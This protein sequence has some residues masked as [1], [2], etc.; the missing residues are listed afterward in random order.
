[1]VRHYKAHLPEVAK[2]M[3]ETRKTSPI[4]TRNPAVFHRRENG[5]YW[6][7]CSVCEVGKRSATVSVAKTFEAT[8]MKTC[9]DKF[10]SVRWMFDPTVEKPSR[11]RTSPPAPYKFKTADVQPTQPEQPKQGLTNEELQ[12]RF[13]GLFDAEWLEVHD[14]STIADVPQEEMLDS[15]QKKYKE[16]QKALAKA[17]RLVDAERMEAEIQR[18]VELALNAKVAVY[19][20]EIAELTAENNTLRCANTTLTTKADM[21]DRECS[22]L[23]KEASKARSAFQTVQGKIAN[24][25]T[26]LTEQGI[27]EKKAETIAKYFLQFAP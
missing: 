10:D 17:E 27:E 4:E 13:P 19:K 3:V 18:R 20:Q 22:S 6:C 1:M 14:Y 5:T 26:V 21:L 16:Q 7:L 15:L 11:K 8:H 9:S 25:E 24:I 23:D 12:K 2:T